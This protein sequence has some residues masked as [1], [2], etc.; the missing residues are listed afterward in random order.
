M[1]KQLLATTAV[2]LVLSLP[3]WAQDTTD[4]I[5]SM[6]EPAAATGAP[7]TDELT[8][9]EGDA[10]ASTEAQAGATTE[11]A[12]ATDAAEAAAEGDGMPAAQEDMAE[13]AAPA[14]ETTAT[15]AARATPAAVIEAQTEGQVRADELMGMTVVSADGQEVGE[16]SDLIF[17]EEEKL[18]G[19]VVGMGG[20]LGI[21][22]KLVGVDW[23]QA[24]LQ[25]DP[26]S[27]KERVFVGLTAADLEA[28]PDFMTKQDA[29]RRAQ[30]EA[31]AGS[32]PMQEPM[33]A[34]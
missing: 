26:Q 1:L 17:N 33:S 10:A 28:A 12:A 5:D 16:V 13:E 21:G 27:E 30:S 2:V 4:T 14:E 18:S 32:Q 19:I 29:Q 7:A 25:T 8:P 31:P 34:E 24:E 15:A 6:E 3:S 11:P 20:F 9:M 22:Q 23:S